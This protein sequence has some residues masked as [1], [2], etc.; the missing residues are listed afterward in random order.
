MAKIG[1]P[2]AGHI[3]H[4][5][6]GSQSPTHGDIFTNGVYHCLHDVEARGGINTDGF[7]AA[8][9]IT[10]IH[11]KLKQSR[12]DSASAAHNRYGTFQGGCPLR[13]AS[14]LWYNRPP[15]HVPGKKEHA[16]VPSGT[17]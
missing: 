8:D 2:R 5:A 3:T 15:K 7:T 4:S 17:W 1:I 16:A 6:A 14:S 11:L 12:N 9:R 10:P 13:S